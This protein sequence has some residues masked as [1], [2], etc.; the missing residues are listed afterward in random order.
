MNGSND[1]PFGLDR[2][3]ED[4]FE[5][6]LSRRLGSMGDGCE[7]RIRR[8]ASEPVDTLALARSSPNTYPFR[9]TLRGRLTWT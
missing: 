5:R 3:A 1:D 2:K 4:R 7:A 8:D 6:L 9:A